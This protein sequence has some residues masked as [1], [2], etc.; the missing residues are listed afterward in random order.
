M[1]RRPRTVGIIGLGY[2]RAHLEGFRAAGC[3]VVAVCQRNDA[4]VKAA[5]K[6]Y[7]V[8]GAYT[9]WEDL[10]AQAKPDIVAIA[11]PPALHLPILKS[12]M[13][14]GAHVLCEKPLAMNRTEALEML[15]V[16]QRTGRAAIT[17]FNWRYPVATRRFREM[18]DAGRL[19]RVFHVN[20]RWLNGAW[21]AESAA[22][23]WRMDR[24][25]AGHGALGDQGVHLIDMIR[26]LFG[27][28]VRVQC[29]SGIAYPSRHAPGGG[30][31]DAEDH[32]TLLGE[33]AGGAQVSF[34]V[35]RVAHGAAEHS[36]EA[37]GTNGALAFRVARSGT[38]WQ[39]GELLAAAPGGALAPV[40]LES[41]GATD[42]DRN[43]IIG[44]ATIA[45]MVRAFLDAIERGEA[46]APSLADG[47]KAQ[48]VLDAALESAQSGRRVEVAGS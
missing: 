2:G 24:A 1:N 17:G 6:Q 18:V 7:G 22:A 30:A 10:I 45:P 3:E 46:P 16:A 8:A 12:A 27:D 37:Y 31:P 20:A 5:A 42:P 21:A 48:A 34:T 13:E 9:R 44:R 47:M 11:T 19:G 28:F 35:S 26:W 33:L 36:L 39:V 14:S 4:A 40:P 25:I 43:A 41:D 38:D 15:A 32:A 23:T 29:Q